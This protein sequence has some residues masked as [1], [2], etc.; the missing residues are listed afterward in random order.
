MRE[1]ATKIVD[2]V[3][4]GVRGV[5]LLFSD[6]GSAGKLF[7]RAVRGASPR[8]LRGREGA[9][10]CGGAG[11]AGA[12]QRRQRRS[13][14]C[15]PASALQPA[16]LAALPLPMRAGGTLKPREVQALRRTV[17]DLL[18]FVPFTI[19]LIIPLTPV[20]HVLIFGFIQRY[21]PGLFPSQFTGRRQELM[22]K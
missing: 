8:G 1:G 2:G 10:G 17:R 20:G 3:L 18:T 22:M 13:A 19:I 12:V 14:A 5:K 9:G 11:A 7:W 16:A 21:F 4:F 15:V 6:I